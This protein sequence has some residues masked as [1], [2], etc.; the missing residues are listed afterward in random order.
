MEN[1]VKYNE[2]F[3]VFTSCSYL[4]NIDI[5]SKMILFVGQFKNSN[6]L[7]ELIF[8]LSILFLLIL[9][10]RI[11]ILIFWRE[12]S[13]INAFFYREF[14][15]MYFSFTNKNIKYDAKLQKRESLKCKRCYIFVQQQLI[16][17]RRHYYDKTKF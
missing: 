4:K 8:T 10:R 15:S 17:K 14:T 11:V 3:T 13:K 12:L 7:S 9:N 1:I 16:I 2:R 5:T 6:I